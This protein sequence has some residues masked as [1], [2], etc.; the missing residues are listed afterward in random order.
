MDKI[1]SEEEIKKYGYTHIEKIPSYSEPKLYPS[2]N[3]INCPSGK[4]KKVKLEKGYI[5]LMSFNVHNFTSICTEDKLKKNIKKFIDFFKKTEVDILLLQEVVP[6]SKTPVFE[7][8]DTY[9]NFDYIKNE[10]NKIGM[11]YSKICN[12][13]RDGLKLSESKGYY[14]L[15]NAIF[16]KIPFDGECYQLPMNRG[17]IIA[18][19]NNLT[20]VNV[21]GEYWNDDLINHIIPEKFNKDLIKYQWDLIEKKLKGIKN[22]IIAGD[23][24]LPYKIWDSPQFYRLRYKNIKERMRWIRE[25]FIDM[26]SERYPI[27]NRNTNLSQNLAT[28]FIMVSKEAKKIKYIN[29][30]IY[31][32][33]LSDHLPLSIDLPKEDIQ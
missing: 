20:V 6:I 11:K 31:D 4:I 1:L 26:L 10:F 3:K 28:D 30:I 7:A 22:L 8:H 9:P 14:Y 15:A 5:R 23:F 24:N 16:S 18:K 21:H 2:E 32:S 13:M 29:P 19:F 33:N 12:N 25:N 27:E 17:I